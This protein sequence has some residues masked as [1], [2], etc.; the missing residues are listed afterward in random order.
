MPKVSVIVPVYNVEQYIEKCILSLV[1]QTLEDIEI[2]FVNDGTKDNSE[3]II[4]N[5]QKQFPDKIKYFKKENGGLSSA[6]NFGIPYAT[7]KYVCFLDSDDY[8]E[9]NMYETM[10]NEA[11]SGNYDMVECNFIWEYP[12]KKRLDIGASYVSQKE[13]LTKAR[14]VAWNKLY[15]REILINSKVRFPEGLRY[16]DVEFFYEI[17]PELKSIGYVKEPFIHYIQRENS[18]INTQNEK[19]KEIFTVLEHVLNYYK[20]NNLWDEYKDEL[21]YIYTRFLLCSSFLRMTKIK[22]KT[23]RKNLL[24]ETWSKLNMTFPNWKKNKHLR[25]KGLKNLYMRTVNKFTYKIY[26]MIFKLIHHK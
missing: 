18:I 16:E 25:E 14:V 8:V 21:E 22:D 4:L 17:L 5:Y 11:T 15:K 2:I 12:N 13:A 6:R 24:V 19:T 7:G 1:N 26:C 10:Y 23:I 20:A 9:T 3:E